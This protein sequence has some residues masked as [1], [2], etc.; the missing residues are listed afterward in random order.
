MQPGMQPAPSSTAI[1]VPPPSGKQTQQTAIVLLLLAIVLGLYGLSQLWGAVDWLISLGLGTEPFVRAGKGI[2][3]LAVAAGAAYFAW[4]KLDQARTEATAYATWERGGGMDRFRAAHAARS[5]AQQAQAAAQYAAVAAQTGTGNLLVP[6]PPRPPAQNG[7]DRFVDEQ[8]GRLLRQGEVILDRG[9]L[10]KE[11]PL[12]VQ[13]IV[14]IGFLLRPLFFDYWLTAVTNQRIILIKT[15]FWGFSPA[16]S[17]KGVD[18]IEL[19]DL[20]RLDVSS[21]AAFKTLVFQSKRGPQRVLR[22]RP[23]GGGFSQQGA[24]HREMPQWVA[25]T[26]AAMNGMAPAGAP[27]SQAAPAQA[28]ALGPAPAAAATAPL[29]AGMPV[30]VRWTDGNAYPA[31]VVASQGDAVLCSFPNGSEEWIPSSHVAAA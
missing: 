27:A 9:F 10:T 13:V 21:F 30:S 8:A 25:A 28:P 14:Q 29:S 23:M 7:H 3:G 1:E 12:L 18:T 26:I 6:Y 5:A 31:R 4:R 19:A 22:V 15:S 11:P 20:A 17:N 24:F 16:L 2:V